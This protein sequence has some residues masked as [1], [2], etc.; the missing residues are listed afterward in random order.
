MLQSRSRARSVQVGSG[1]RG[2]ASAVALV[3]W[4]EM[5]WGNVAAQRWLRVEAM[6]GR[7]L[8]FGA[9]ALAG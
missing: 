6:A 2:G 8:V 7:W 3:G 1:A 9:A 4:E 5:E